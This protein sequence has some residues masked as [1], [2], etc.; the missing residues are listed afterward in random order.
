M[1]R[2]LFLYVSFIL[3][4]GMAVLLFCTTA[5]AGCGPNHHYVPDAD[6]Q[7]AT[8]FLYA[9]EECDFYGIKE[10][11]TCTACGVKRT[12]VL[13]EF[14]VASKPHDFIYSKD[15]GHGIGEHFHEY[16]CA[17]CERTEIRTFICD[18]PPCQAIVAKKPVE[19]ETEQVEP[20]EAEV[21]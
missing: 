1:K 10:R 14:G 20:V 2:K 9:T 15:L 6:N 11:Q 12:I 3:L 8:E 18:G 13:E 17:V 19:T 4:C 5:Y 21:E 16:R 7:Y